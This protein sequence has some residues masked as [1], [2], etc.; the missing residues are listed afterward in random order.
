VAGARDH[1]QLR[2]GYPG[3]QLLGDLKR[4]S[5][6]RIS[7]H[8]QRRDVDRRQDLAQIRVRERVCHGSHA[9]GPEVPHHLELGLNDLRR[10][11]GGEER[12]REVGDDLAR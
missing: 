12:L 8:E 9:R 3:V 10:H 11:L 7:M 1:D 5:L 2:P 4:G 6:I